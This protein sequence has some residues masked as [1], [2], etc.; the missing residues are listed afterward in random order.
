MEKFMVF[1]QFTQSNIETSACVCEHL[2]DTE[3]R[4]RQYFAAGIEQPG[5]GKCGLQQQ[6][7]AGPVDKVIVKICA[8]TSPV[9]TSHSLHPP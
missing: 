1:P 7:K 9:S 6:R 5:G 3:I 2:W 4:K 8:R